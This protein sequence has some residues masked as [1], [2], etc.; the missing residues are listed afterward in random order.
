MEEVFSEIPLT[1][2]RVELE[3][4]GVFWFHTLAQPRTKYVHVPLPVIHNHPLTLAFLGRPV[5]A[6]Y[7][8]VSLQPDRVSRFYSPREVWE[9]HGFYVYPA[10]ARKSVVKQVTMSMSGTGLVQLKPRTRA[11]VPDWTGHRVY[12]PGTVFETYMLVDEDRFSPPGIVRLGAKR[13]G[14][15]RVR[16]RRAGF[17]WLKSGEATH[18]FNVSEARAD[19]YRTI[20]YH[21]AGDVALYGRVSPA[22]AVGDSVLAV[23]SFLLD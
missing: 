9:E 18:P 1:V 8:S 13:F 2:Y 20:L 14:V 5:D 15:F 23:P 17:R 22:L 16:A 12:L 7:A 21:Y 11:P 3:L 19:Y 4:H 6:A 10:L